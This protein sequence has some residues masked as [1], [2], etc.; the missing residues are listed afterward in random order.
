[1]DSPADLINLIKNI[2]H[3]PKRDLRDNNKNGNTT[4]PYGNGDIEEDSYD[5]HS[6]III[7]DFVKNIQS[8]DLDKR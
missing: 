2:F 8:L 6:C 4:N 5:N 3:P 1:M 7:P